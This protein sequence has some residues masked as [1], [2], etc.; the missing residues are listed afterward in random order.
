MR[1]HW[2]SWRLWTLWNARLDRRR[3]LPA[4]DAKALSETERQIQTGVNQT[5]RDAEHQYAEKADPL[6]AKLAE[7]RKALGSIYEPEYEKLQ[8]RAGRRDVRIHMGRTAHLIL[9]GLLTVGEMAFNLVAFNV[10]QEPG[11]FTALMA[12]AVG[13]AIPICAWAV[14]VWVR[15]WPPPWWETLLKI[16]VVTLVV[17]AVLVGINEVRLA[18]LAELAPQVPEAPPQPSLPDFAVN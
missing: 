3:N 7:V 15:Q 8:E 16:A 13:V 2:F 10:F 14:G 6:E 5:I 18:Y 11:F 1:R 12:L 4:P 17:V 9:L